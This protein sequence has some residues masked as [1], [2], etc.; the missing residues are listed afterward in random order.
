MNMECNRY[1]IYPAVGIA[2]VGNSE[3]DFLISPE[4]KNQELDQQI[5]YKDA[6]GRLK[7]HAARF[8]IYEVDGSGRVIR[9]VTQDDTTHITW[10]VHIANRKAINYEFNNAMDLGPLAISSTL[11]NPDITDLQ[12]RRTKLLLDPGKR[13]ISGISMQQNN[14]HKGDNYVFDGAQFYKGTVHQQDVYLGEL[15]TDG[16]GRLLVLGGR[17]HSASFDGKPAITFANNQGWHDDIA[18]GT[19]RATVCIN[20]EHFDAEPAMVAVTPPNFAP[21]IEGTV[22]LLDVVEN[23]F[24][25]KKLIEPITDVH[26]YRDIY[27]IFSSLVANQAVNEGFYFLF[28]ENAPA[29]FTRKDIRDKLADSSNESKHFRQSVFRQFRPS[30]SIAK[31]QRKEALEKITD[32]NRPDNV[33]LKLQTHGIAES[34]ISASQEALQADML[35]P[36]Y[37]DAY[38]EYPDNPLANLSLT[39]RQYEMLR[40]WSEGDF[41]EDCEVTLT[42]IADVPLQEQ[43]QALTHGH[44]SHCLGGPFHPGIELTWFLRRISMWNT[45]DS[46]DP[47]RLNILPAQQEPQDYFGPVLTPDIALTE[48]FNASGPG[49]LTRFM[50]VPWQTDE[51]SCRSGQDY[52]PAY[53][54]PVASF[55]S[56]RVPNQ[57]LSERSLKRIQDNSLPSLQRLKHL[58]L[59]QDWL[60]FFNLTKYQ[61]EYQT[62]INGM[63]SDWY[64]VGV[65]KEQQIEPPLCI[66]GFE[67]SS[68]WVESEVNIKFTVNDPSFRQL[69]HMENITDDFNDSYIKN[70]REL[71]Q[72]DIDFS[73]SDESARPKFTRNQLFGDKTS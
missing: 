50:G 42:S 20:G 67:L 31:L 71:E 60:R 1:Y 61:T 34:A 3:S 59:R 25:Q 4:L 69:L 28:G 37:G 22:T 27:P 6:L 49:T 10:Q 54:L 70:L 7:P 73:Q 8:R 68:L 48:M 18:D 24:E 40:C 12:E 51:A 33:G 45:A 52:D 2:R 53:Y 29:Q 43:P 62:Q 39:D 9:E 55:W 23:L 13:E 44:L 57:V 66:E 26:F 16:K 36:F 15:R 19:V 38:G 47:M 30:E 63:V 14:A 5:M 21:G 17:G 11:R 72:D 58:D 41:N 32:G 64:K 65:V 46:F 35:P 56:A